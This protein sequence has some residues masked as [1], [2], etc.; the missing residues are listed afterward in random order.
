MIVVELTKEEYIALLRTVEDPD[1]RMR[2]KQFAHSAMYGS[3][4]NA[5]VILPVELVNG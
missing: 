3:D 5:K 2:M 4:P 1:R